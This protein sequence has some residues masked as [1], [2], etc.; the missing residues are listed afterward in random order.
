[1]T[2]YNAAVQTESFV[3]V[4]M[5]GKSIGTQTDDFVQEYSPLRYEHVSRSEEAFRA[6]TGIRNILRRSST[7]Q[8]NL[9]NLSLDFGK[10]ASSILKGFHSYSKNVYA[11][12]T[13]NR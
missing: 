4:G 3:C 10:Q 7:R 13:R 12:K 1:M 11:V 2:F 8:K 6:Y 5:P 9:A